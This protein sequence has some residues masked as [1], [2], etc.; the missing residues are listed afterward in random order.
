[1]PVRSAANRAGPLR[2]GTRSCWVPHRTR[3]F[4]RRTACSQSR[5]RSEPRGRS[6]LVARHRVCHEGQLPTWTPHPLELFAFYQRHVRKHRLLS[7]TFFRGNRLH[8]PA[9]PSL[10]S[11][12]R[13]IF[14]A[15]HRRAGHPPSERLRG[16]APDFRCHG[17]SIMAPD[18]S[19]TSARTRSTCYRSFT[20][21]SATTSAV[22]WRGFG[23]VVLRPR[24][25]VIPASQ[26]SIARQHV[27]APFNEVYAAAGLPRTTSRTP[28]PIRHFVR[29]PTNPESAGPSSTTPERRERYVAALRHRLWGTPNGVSPRKR[30]SFHTAPSPT[31]PPKLTRDCACTTDT[32]LRPRE[33]GRPVLNKPDTAARLY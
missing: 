23:G 26:P 4:T 12:T 24:P 1:V 7:P 18:T 27:S 19:T 30:C 21:F 31:P 16:H 14:G 10:L 28:R 2:R 3:W 32:G 8:S 13:R 15:Q 11:R 25:A 6:P 20:T 17:D 5:A 29:Q 9:A 22:R 33:D